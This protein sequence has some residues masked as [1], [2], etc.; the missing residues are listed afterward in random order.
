[1]AVFLLKAEHGSDYDPPDCAGVFSDVPCT[2][3]VGFPDWIEQL[4]AEHVTGGC[5]TDPLQYCPARAVTRAEMA[6][7]LLKS[8]HGSGYAPDP[9]A[10]IFTDVP[11]PATPEFPFSDWI[12]QLYAEA[13][14]GGCATDPLRY[15]PDNPNLRGEMAVFLTKTFGFP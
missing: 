15:C 8:E 14:T 6:V 13:I 2:P 4:Y 12:E 7:F 11:C 10:G 9:C 1:M 5:V 3:G